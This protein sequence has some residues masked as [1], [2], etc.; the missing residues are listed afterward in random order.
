MLNAACTFLPKRISMVETTLSL[1]INP[2]K[3]EVQ[4]RQSPS[5]IGL[6]KGTRTPASR[7]MMLSEEFSTRL[8][9][10]SKLCK[11]R[12][13]T[14][15]YLENLY[16]AKMSAGISKKG[17]AHILCFEGETISDSFAPNGEKLTVALMHL[18]LSVI[19]APKDEFSSDKKMCFLFLL[20]FIA[21]CNN[22]N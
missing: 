2:E 17:N 7:A 5:P 12:K 1:A 20:K 9:C 11:N 15:Y 22:K 3:R 13:E 14:E 10:R 8:K 21:K 19:F 4:I 6:K 18:L 16:G